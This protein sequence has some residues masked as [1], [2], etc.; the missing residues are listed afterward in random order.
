[1]AASTP[2]EAMRTIKGSVALVKAKVEVR[3]TI[4]GMFAT[5]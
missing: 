4:P 3:G 1:M 5:Q 2:A